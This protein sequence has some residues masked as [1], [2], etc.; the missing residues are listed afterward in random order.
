[1]VAQLILFVMFQK[2]DDTVMFVTHSSSVVSFPTY[3][4]ILVEIS[5]I[6]YRYF[7]I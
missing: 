1:M 5:H 3:I 7:A 4:E 2:N 6:L